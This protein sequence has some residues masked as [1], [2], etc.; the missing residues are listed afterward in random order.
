MDVRSP[1]RPRANL[2][3]STAHPRGA[4]QNC[5]GVSQITNSNRRPPKKEQ[6]RANRI[7]F[8]QDPVEQ[9]YRSC[10]PSD[11]PPAAAK[12]RTSKSKRKVTRSPKAVLCA[13]SEAVNPALGMERRGACFAAFVYGA[14][15][16]C[17]R[18]ATPD[19]I[20]TVLHQLLLVAR[21]CLPTG[22]HGTS[23]CARR[24]TQR[25]GTPIRGPFHTLES[26]GN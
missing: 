4:R 14:F 3:R 13:A 25:C 19:C 10:I 24:A 20:G 2:R 9:G 11:R 5:R 7:T 8:G 26:T 12:D 23:C 6:E 1:L 21:D 17:P 22:N 18:D 16:A 15:G